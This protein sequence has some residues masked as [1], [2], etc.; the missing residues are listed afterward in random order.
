MPETRFENA[1]DLNIQATKMLTIK[2]CD[3][4]RKIGM[5]DVFEQRKAFCS[6]EKFK[7]TARVCF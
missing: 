2:S 3:T 7:A 4:N 5:Q 1:N 6:Q